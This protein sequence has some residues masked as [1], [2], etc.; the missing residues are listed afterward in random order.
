MVSYPFGAQNQR[1]YVLY[2]MYQNVDRGFGGTGLNYYHAPFPF[3]LPYRT[4]IEKT[5]VWPN[6]YRNQ[7]YSNYEMQARR[8]WL[9]SRT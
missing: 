1:G 5:S 6:S 2:I 9:A 4:P 8:D 7:H 3:E